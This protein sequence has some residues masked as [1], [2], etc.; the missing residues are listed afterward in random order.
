MSL[1]RTGKA[2]VYGDRIDTDLLAPGAYM[3]VPLAELATHCLEAIDP[4][5]A[6]NVDAGD[7]IFG[8]HGFGIGS[9]RE[10][11]AE[12]LLHLG[13]GAI[14]AKSFARIFYRNAINLGLPL[15]ICDFGDSIAKG[16]RVQ[17]DAATGM[18]E[19]MTRKISLQGEAL[20]DFLLD[21]ITAGGL[22]MQL[23]LEINQKARA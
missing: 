11:A 18:I 23:Q 10:Q 12:A 13:I 14:V 6:Q 19:N 4:H 17:L 21:T 5:F 20:P 15:I 1:L 16:D 9:S 22:M 7:V 3:K 8:G 2:W